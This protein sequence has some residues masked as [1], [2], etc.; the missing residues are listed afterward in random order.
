MIVLPSW[1]ARSFSSPIAWRTSPSLSVSTPPRWL[2]TGSMMISPTFPI[3]VA[4][5]AHPL[6]VVGE[7]DLAGDERDALEVAGRLR[8]EVRCRPPLSPRRTRRSRCAARR[9]RPA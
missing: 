2:P 5:V 9:R 7:L 1:F 3:V 4:S 6:D 8:G